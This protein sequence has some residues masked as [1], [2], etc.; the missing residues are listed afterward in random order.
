MKN[1]TTINQYGVAT[2][3]SPR[4]RPLPARCSTSVNVYAQL[5]KTLSNEPGGRHKFSNFVFF[6]GTLQATKE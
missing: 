4:K 1:K 5:K 6:H 3:A 2:V